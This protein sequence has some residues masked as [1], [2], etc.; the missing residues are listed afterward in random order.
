MNRRGFTFGLGA[1]FGAPKVG[2]GTIAAGLGSV[3]PAV[4]H[5]YFRTAKI[6]ARAHNTCS[7]QFLMRHLRV[8]S[9]IAKQVEGM[10]ID[11][12][13]ITLP[14]LNG[15]SRAVNP[16]YSSPLPHKPVATI[17]SPDFS[18]KARQTLNE[19]CAELTAQ[20]CNEP[21][22]GQDQAD[23]AVPT[24]HGDTQEIPSDLVASG[25]GRGQDLIE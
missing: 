3:S 22:D 25:D 19:P 14:G 5:E 23:D 15:I 13:V 2:L 1:L 4:L 8:D 12:K 9:T 10:L 17:Q 21:D 6:I 20:E 16:V 24:C 11:G 7:Q 18:T